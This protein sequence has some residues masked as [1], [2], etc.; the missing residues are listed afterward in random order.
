MLLK[1]YSPGKKIMIGEIE[2]LCKSGNTNNFGILSFST[3]YRHLNPKEQIIL[4]KSADLSAAANFLFQA[5][6]NI[7]LWKTDVVY[8][9][10]A[11]NYGIGRAINDRLMRAS[12]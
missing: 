11:P 6:R 4:S 2:D 9:E 8:A 3:D 5:L 1:H 7:A 12:A 10:M